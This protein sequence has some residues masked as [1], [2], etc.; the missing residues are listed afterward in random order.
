MK[1]AIMS[2]FIYLKQLGLFKVCLD[3]VSFFFLNAIQVPSLGGMK[4]LKVKVSCC[5]PGC[6][7]VQLKAVPKQTWTIALS[8][9][10]PSLAWGKGKT[11]WV[12]HFPD[13]PLS[14]SILPFA[15]CSQSILMHVVLQSAEVGWVDILP[16]LWHVLLA[17]VWSGLCPLALLVILVGDGLQ[18][19]CTAWPHSREPWAQ[20]CSRAAVVFV[21]IVFRCGMHEELCALWLGGALLSLLVSSMLLTAISLPPPSSCHS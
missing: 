4:G 15:C 13:C 2:L 18:W 11:S 21:K 16:W 17:A 5:S 10:S 9:Y 8:L 7:C 14:S 12:S 3:A 19:C 6:A 1:L 20:A